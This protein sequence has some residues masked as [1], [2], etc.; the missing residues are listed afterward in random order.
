VAEP[1]NPPPNAAQRRRIAEETKRFHTRP[2]FALVSTSMLMRGVVTAINW[3]RPPA[4][5]FA[6][7]DSFNAAVAWVESHRGRK[8]ATATKLLAEA[9]ASLTENR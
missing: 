7:F 2:L 8:V 4:Y 3:I 6:T 1:G 5:E 9:R